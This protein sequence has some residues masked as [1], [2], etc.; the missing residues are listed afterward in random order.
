[1]MLLIESKIHCDGAQAKNERTVCWSQIS[2]LPQLHCSLT[3]QPLSHLQGIHYVTMDQR[4]KK[5]NCV[6]ICQNG[7]RHV[8][9]HLALLPSSGVGNGTCQ[10]SQSRAH[11]CGIHA[12]LLYPSAAC[13]EVGNFMCLNPHLKMHIC[14]FFGDLV[15]PTLFLEPSVTLSSRLR[16]REWNVPLWL[17]GQGFFAF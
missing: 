7:Q 17:D 3:I 13:S 15:V 5:M 10:I 9:F 1:M 4:Q 16:R 12:F 8:S 2:E 14:I 6:H 11:L